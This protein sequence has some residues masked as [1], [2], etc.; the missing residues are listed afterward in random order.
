MENSKI[1]RADSPTV[2][3]VQNYGRVVLYEEMG[4]YFYLFVRRNSLSAGN[5]NAEIRYH[6]GNIV[7]LS[8]YFDNIFI[9]TASIFNSTDPFILAV[10]KAVINHKTFREMLSLGV[11]KIVGWGGNSPVEMFNA[12]KNFSS[13]A[14]SKKHSDDYLSIVAS[15][16]NP[17]H[18]VKRS[19]SRPDDKTI[20]MFK[21]RL[22]Q[23]TIIRW[24]SDLKKIETAIES[25]A[26]KTGQLVAVSFNPTVRKLRLSR[27][28]ISNVEISFIQ[29]WHDNLESE[30]PGVIVYAPLSNT[31][32][33]E[34]MTVAQEKSVRTFL[35]SPQIFASFLSGY[36]KAK[37]FNKILRQPYKELMKVRNGD[38]KRFANA[39]H[40]AIISVSQNIGHL[41]HSDIDINYF[42]DKNSWAASIMH[43]VDS[44]A[45]NIDISAFIESLTM[46]S[47]ILLSLP[48]MAPLFKAINLVTGQKTNDLF[49]QIKKEFTS[50]ISPFII[51]LA[52]NYEFNGAHT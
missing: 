21:K 28:T 17:S 5:L 50:D 29:S 18:T 45:S 42:Q 37:D 35:Y 25:S 1:S 20:D 34:E 52:K 30:L 27:E 2:L 47:G 19:L 22:G 14:T 33:I 7:L 41:C 8:L 31:I 3:S 15:I 51:K 32:F 26:Q 24:P 38:W 6:I 11:L 43:S 48:Y 10:S 23:T 40:K 44:D 13:K 36:I 39:Y 49:N 16:F 12:A 46:L 4:E 9:Q